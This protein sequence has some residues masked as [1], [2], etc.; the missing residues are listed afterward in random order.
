MT[1]EEWEACKED[2]REA[3]RALISARM[4]LGLPQGTRVRHP[5]YGPGT[6]E[7]TARWNNLDQAAVTFDYNGLRHPCMVDLDI[8][9]DA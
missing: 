7:Y 2:L 3:K 1:K 9:E 5:I 6:F 8:L 4:G